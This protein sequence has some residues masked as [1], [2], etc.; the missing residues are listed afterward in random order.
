MSVSLSAGITQKPRDRSHQLFLR[1]ACGHGAVILASA[2]VR[3]CV[4]PHCTL[5]ICVSSLASACAAALFS[6]CMMSP[7]KGAAR[8]Q[9]GAE[10]LF[11]TI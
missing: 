2:A 1:V 6:T 10:A 3:Y 5:A 7:G 9:L 8:Q 4:R 11:R